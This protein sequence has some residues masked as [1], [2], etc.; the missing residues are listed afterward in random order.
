MN[1]A[2][3]GIKPPLGITPNYIWIEKR[4]QEIEQGIIR[5][6]MAD[7]EIPEDWKTELKELKER[8]EG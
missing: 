4:I 7:Y 1:K 8:M 3:R 5:F 2:H 6:V